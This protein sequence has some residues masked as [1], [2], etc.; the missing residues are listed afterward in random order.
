MKH[1]FERILGGAGATREAPAADDEGYFATQF[2]ERPE[3][4]RATSAWTARALGVGA[5]ALPADEGLPLLN[6]AWGS[7]HFFAALMPAER[8]Q[9]GRVLEFVTVPAGRELIHQDEKGDY[10]LIILSGVVAV[11]RVQPTG[12]RARLA[13]AREGDVVGEMSLLDAGARFAS[14]LTLT[15]CRL[16]VLTGQALDDMAIDDPRIGMALTYS[17]ARRLSLRT[18]QLSARLGA[19]LASQGPTPR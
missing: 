1:L 18:R 9:V 7:D 16:A 3:A 4:V 6:R 8:E 2:M 12:E 19:L 15:P 10:A 5:H 13:E 17:L 11:D 14:C